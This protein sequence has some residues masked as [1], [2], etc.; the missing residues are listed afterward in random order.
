MR[1]TLGFGVVS[2]TVC[3]MMLA[4][5]LVS[6]A[7]AQGEDT[8]NRL[9]GRVTKIGQPGRSGISMQGGFQL[10]ERLQ[11]NRAVV[12]VDALL[13]EEGGAGELLNAAFPITVPLA[14]G[15]K[16]RV[17]SFATP[18]GVSPRI[19]LDI[20]T[21]RTEPG[22]FHMIVTGASVN[23][24]ALCSPARISTTPLRLRFTI[25]DGVIDPVVVEGDAIWQCIGKVR[26]TPQSLRAVGAVR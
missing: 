21:S 4:G 18:R 19:R 24:P 9:A 1:R 8:L 17:A 3:V 2:W 7:A 22:S 13:E 6:E 15:A 11:L 20:P 25:S 14:P 10:E 23:M 26:T 12:V 5:G 16:P